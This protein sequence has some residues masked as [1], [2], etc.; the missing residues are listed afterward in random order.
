M[1]W[2]APAHSQW[3][4]LI[5][6]TVNGRL[7]TWYPLAVLIGILIV[8][9]CCGVITFFFC[10]PFVY[11]YKKYKQKGAY[12]RWEEMQSDMEKAPEA[13]TEEQLRR[14]SLRKKWNLK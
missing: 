12:V 6:W 3:L 8:A 14:E 11:A 13:P 10:N 1:L 2:Y 7:Y 9:C 5:K 4:N